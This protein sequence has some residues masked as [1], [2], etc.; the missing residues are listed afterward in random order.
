MVCAA[1][2]TP[3]LFRICNLKGKY[4]VQE[5]AANCP[6]LSELTVKESV[7][8]LLGLEAEFVIRQRVFEHVGKEWTGGSSIA[9][10]RGAA[11]REWAVAS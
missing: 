11:S 10:R 6:F 1:L 9:E 2:R 8:H 4:H 7:N 3:C 5:H